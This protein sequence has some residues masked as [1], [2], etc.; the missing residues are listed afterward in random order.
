MVSVSQTLWLHGQAGN[1]SWNTSGCDILILFIIFIIF[2]STLD[3][4]L[5]SKH[6]IFSIVLMLLNKY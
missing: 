5:F 2:Q 4:E 3:N 6:Q 1:V